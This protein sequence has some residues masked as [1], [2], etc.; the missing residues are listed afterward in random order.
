MIK[1]TSK[2][3]EV[4]SLNLNNCNVCFAKLLKDIAEI[5]GY[6]DLNL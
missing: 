6:D 5:L 4:C 3:W 1:Y 2:S